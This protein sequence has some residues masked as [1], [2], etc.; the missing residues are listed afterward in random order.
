MDY[1]RDMEWAEKEQLAEE[2]ENGLFNDRRILKQIVLDKDEEYLLRSAAL[3]HID[4]QDFL[5]SVASDLSMDSV[6]RGSAMRRITDPTMIEQ[7]AN[8]KNRRSLFLAVCYASLSDEK[9]AEILLSNKDDDPSTRK[10]AVSAIKD[11]HVLLRLYEEKQDDDA[12]RSLLVN[13]CRDSFHQLFRTAAQHDPCARIRRT[14]VHRLGYL[15]DWVIQRMKIEPDPEV[16]SSI[17]SSMCTW[18]DTNPDV[19][20]K[21]LAEIILARGDGEEVADMI[22]H[23]GHDFFIERLIKE[24]G[25]NAPA[26]LRILKDRL[27]EIRDFYTIKQSNTWHDHTNGF[28]A[29]YPSMDEFEYIDSHYDD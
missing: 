21:K 10:N 26:A 27:W 25:D 7:L 5:F 20:S 18:S 11:E 29:G 24:I 19:I 6:L 14:C 16:V 28:P 2:I 9:L 12:F 15:D 3:C 17:V 4:D 8:T 13:E 22:P 23:L 1:R